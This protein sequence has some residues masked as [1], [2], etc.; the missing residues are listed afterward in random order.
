MENEKKLLKPDP[1]DIKLASEAAP[2]DLKEKEKINLFDEILDWV[3]SFVFALF[4]II[5]IFIFFLRIVTV[6]G[7]SMNN[8]LEDKDRLILTHLNYT[9]ARDDVVVVNS[10]V[11]RH[12]GLKIPR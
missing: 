1:E 7:P 8:T 4:V 11:G 12:K 10:T 9:P 3:E 6:D 5:L 2:D